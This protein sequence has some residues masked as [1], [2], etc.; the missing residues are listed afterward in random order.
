MVDERK[1]KREKPKR[2]RKRDESMLPYV[3]IFAAAIVLIVGVA[4]VFLLTREP[5]I[6]CTNSGPDCE[7]PT[8]SLVPNPLF[9]TPTPALPPEQIGQQP[10]NGQSPMISSLALSPDEQYL[11]ISLNNPYQAQV[12]G[13]IVSMHLAQSEEGQPTFTE[14]MSQWEL[15]QTHLRQVDDID[16]HPNGDYFTLA[17]SLNPFV[18]VYDVSMDNISCDYKR[19]C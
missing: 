14:D 2:K 6:D 18:E 7:F 16:I 9:P 8:P 13:E 17:S 4:G 10:S 1:P 3:A 12:K 19:C 5:E 11:L 15:T